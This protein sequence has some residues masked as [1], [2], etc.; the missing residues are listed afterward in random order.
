MAAPATALEHEVNQLVARRPER[1]AYAI[2][3]VWHQV[4][5]PIFNIPLSADGLRHLDDTQVCSLGKVITR[6][7]YTWTQRYRDEEALNWILFALNNAQLIK[8]RYLNHPVEAS[9]PSAIPLEALT[10]DDLRCGDQ[11]VAALRRRAIYTVPRTWLANDVRTE[12]RA[13]WHF[14]G[15][16]VSAILESHILTPKLVSKLRNC[17]NRD[18]TPNGYL[19]LPSRPPA[20]N[21]ILPAAVRYAL[22]RPTQR[23]LR[24]LL[25][26]LRTG[27]RGAPDETVPPFPKWLCVAFPAVCGGS[28]A[29]LSGSR[30]KHIPG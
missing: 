5:I 4:R 20:D 8:S 16:V 9:R 22:A 2:L 3:W 17:R 14:C 19:A 21:I 24:L 29:Q 11:F 18:L 12:R 26:A 25:K 27:H 6:N 7:D 30:I 1:S 23:H 28:S 15:F 10:R 13:L